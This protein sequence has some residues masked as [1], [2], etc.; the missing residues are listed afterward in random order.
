MKKIINGFVDDYMSR[1]TVPF[2]KSLEDKTDRYIREVESRVPSARKR[3]L[4]TQLYSKRESSGSLAGWKRYVL[5]NQS[6]TI[7][8]LEKELG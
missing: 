3:E 2:V 6:K 5:L 4:L 1:F 8:E 7:A